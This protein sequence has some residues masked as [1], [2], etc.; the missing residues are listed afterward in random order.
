MTLPKGHPMTLPTPVNS[1]AVTDKPTK[2]KKV[3]AR[4]W[5]LLP[6]FAILLVVL[7]NLPRYQSYQNIVPTPKEQ[8]VLPVPRVPQDNPEILRLREYA[9]KHKLEWSV[10]I[11]QSGNNYCA[12]LGW[13]TA[14]EHTLKEAVDEEM[15]QHEQHERSY[16]PLASGDERT[17]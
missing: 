7:T 16:V 4:L 3:A 15:E 5:M 9:I 12:S 6:A 10:N 13:Q 8:A 17:R 11:G 2:V 14:C 1:D